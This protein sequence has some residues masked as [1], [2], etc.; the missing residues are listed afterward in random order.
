VNPPIF[1]STSTPDARREA[2]LYASTLF[3][4]PEGEIGFPPEPWI[5]KAIYFPP[6]RVKIVA[7]VTNARPNPIKLNRVGDGIPRPA[8]MKNTRA[9]IKRTN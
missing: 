3:I 8:R 1:F 7:A 4:P 5:L 2:F 6:T 9:K